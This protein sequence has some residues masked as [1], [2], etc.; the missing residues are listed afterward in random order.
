[1]GGVDVVSANG[2]GNS[3]AGCMA[4]SCKG[5]LVDTI[6]GVKHSGVGKTYGLHK[7]GRMHRN[8]ANAAP[9]YYKSTMKA[10]QCTKATAQLWGVLFAN[11]SIRWSW[12]YILFEGMEGCFCYLA[13]SCPGQHQK[14]RWF[15]VGVYL[16]SVPC[17]IL[18]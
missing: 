5:T 2:V 10:G 9:H 15:S 6:N 16:D 7:H 8:E 1:M 12:T 11:F 14:P 17:L 3:H 18:R 13:G 4:C